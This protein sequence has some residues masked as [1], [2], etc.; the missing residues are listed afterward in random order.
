[1][2]CRCIRT[3]REIVENDRHH[4]ARS[5]EAHCAMA[6]PGVDGNVVTPIHGITSP[7][8]VRA[9]R[10]NVR[11]DV[12]KRAPARPDNISPKGRGGPMP[13]FDERDAMF[14][15]VGLRPAARLPRQPPRRKPRPRRAHRAPP[16]W[17]PRLH[18]RNGPIPHQLRPQHSNVHKS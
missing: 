3:S 17:G 9:R 1:M 4:D 18:R 5:L 7:R 2:D 8:C 14:C 6:D 12:V 15:R 10:I 16:P 11:V 13:R